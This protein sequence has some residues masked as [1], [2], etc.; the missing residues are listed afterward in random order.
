M[1]DNDIIMYTVKEIRAI[2]KCSKNQ[3]YD[4]VNASGFPS[5]KIGGKILTEKRALEKWIDRNR[6][7]SIAL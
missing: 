4:I 1:N 3:A 5:M 6:G 2:F 7:R